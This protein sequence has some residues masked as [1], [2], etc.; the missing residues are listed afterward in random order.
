MKRRCTSRI[1][2]R[3]TVMM[4]ATVASITI[5]CDTSTDRPGVVARDSAEVVILDHLILDTTRASQLMFPASPSVRIGVVDGEAIYQLFHVGYAYQQVNGTIVVTNSGTAEVRGYDRQGTWQW[6]SGHQG[7]GPGEFESLAWARPYRGDSIVAFDR[8]MGRVSILSPRGAYVRSFQPIAP[9]DHPRVR[10]EGA[11]T[12]GSVL[13]SY[14]IRPAGSGDSSRA[15]R[16]TH[17]YGIFNTEGGFVRAVGT[18]VDDDQFVWADGSRVSVGGI[19]FGRTTATV[20]LEETFVVGDNTAFEARTYDQRGALKQILRVDM[21][22]QPLGHDV[23]DRHRA[24]ALEEIPESP[25]RPVQ[26]RAL[27]AT[28]YP[29]HLPYY[30]DVVVA[31]PSGAYWIQVAPEFDQAWDRWLV[32]EHGGAYRG[33]YAIPR[34]L[35]ITDV[36]DGFVV[37]VA[38]DQVGVQ[39]VEV[40]DLRVG[41]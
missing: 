19:P 8:S 25:F 31:R 14:G 35:R 34:P 38:T 20:V 9:G 24:A 36:G 26:Q 10:L 5:A 4:T 21:D 22:R 12:D 15:E 40:Y 3:L 16:P 29:S 23:A 41:K 30:G 1:R 13:A 2:H 7:G 27:Q 33:W 17:Q 32:F 28:P 39:F 18:F 6:S 11:F 37:G